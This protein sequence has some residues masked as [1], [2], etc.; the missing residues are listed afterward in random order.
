MEHFEVLMRDYIEKVVDVEHRDPS[1]DVLHVDRVVN[2]AKIIGRE[3]NANL[4][5]IVPAAYLHDCVY[6]SKTDTRRKEA[7]RISA[8]KA[9]ELLKYWGYPS[10]HFAEIHHAIL[11][12]SFSAGIPASTLEAK[13]VQDAD[14]LEAL[15]AIGIIRCF[16]LGGMTGRPLYSKEDPFCENRKADDNH[17]TLDHFY[18]KLLGLSKTLH[19]PWAKKEGCIRLERLESFLLSLQNEIHKCSGGHEKA[20]QPAH[21]NLNLI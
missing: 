12:H 19:T 7:S 16:T 15:G 11:A 6:I 8:D 13:I 1:H 10:E 18:I 5:V 14:R 20:E 4:H 9:I 3:M 2:V 21:F 17:N